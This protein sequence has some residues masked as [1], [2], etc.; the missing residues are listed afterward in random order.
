MG[1]CPFRHG[2][3]PLACEPK[4]PVQLLQWGHAFSGMDIDPHLQ[5][6]ALPSVASMGPCPFRHGYCPPYPRAAKQHNTLQW[7]HAL[8]GMDTRQFT[9]QHLIA[10]NASMGPCP[11]RHG[12]KPTNPLSPL[13]LRASMGPCPFRHGYSDKLSKMSYAKSCFNGAMPFQAWISIRTYNGVRYR[14]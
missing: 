12:Y 10:R 14:R 2:Y 8:S 13:P 6:C 5:W 11:F 9:R 1:P 7:G 3:V 4:K